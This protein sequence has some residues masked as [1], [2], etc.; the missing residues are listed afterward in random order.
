VIAVLAA[1]G[2][3]LT[4]G[5]SNYMAGL[6]SRRS[7]LFAVVF[8][9]QLAALV[10]ALPLALLSGEPFP[11]GP[12]LPYGLAAGV[13]QAIAL[14]AF[15][16][17]LAIG[18]VSIVAPIGA[19]GVVLPV[20]AGFASGDSVA[21][22][23]VAGMGLCVAGIAVAARRPESPESAR[24]GAGGRSVALALVAATSFGLQFIA[25]A[26]SSA[27]GVLWPIALARAASVT[28]LVAA[29]LAVRP[30]LVTAP[31]TLPLIALVGVLNHVA[32][33][34]FVLAAGQEGAPLSVVSVLASLYPAVTVVL[35]LALLGERLARWQALGVGGALLGVVLTAAGR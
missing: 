23:Q 25:F 12:G 15:Y 20:L 26:E 22:A 13:G 1:L 6:Q 8:L 4:Y 34:L 5:V 3:S 27:D 18:T 14:G 10:V 24:R 21:A 17:A 28:V 11:D 7:A 31:G 2:C 9:S 30:S 33:G 35:A 32:S 29:V 19:V 16:R